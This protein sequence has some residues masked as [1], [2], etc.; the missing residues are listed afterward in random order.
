MAGPAVLLPDGPQL[1]DHRPE[2][3]PGPHLDPGGCD[4]VRRRLHIHLLGPESRRLPTHGADPGPDLGSAGPPSRVRGVTSTAADRR[5]G[6]VPADRPGGVRGYL[7]A[8]GG[9][10]V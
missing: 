5:S 7:A 4:W 8:G 2:I 9:G 6:E 10:Y 1:S 3:Q